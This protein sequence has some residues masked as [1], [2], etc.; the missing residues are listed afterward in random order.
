M[1]AFYPRRPSEQAVVKGVCPSPPRH[2]PPFLSRIRFSMITF[3]L[4][5]SSIF[6]EFIYNTSSNT[7]TITTTT[8]TTTTAA[9]ST[10]QA[11]E[12]AALDRSPKLPPRHSRCRR[13]NKGDPT[14]ICTTYYAACVAL[15]RVLR[16]TPHASHFARHAPHTLPRAPHITPR[17]PRITPHHKFRRLHHT[18]RRMLRRVSHV[19][20]RTHHMLRRAAVVR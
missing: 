2:L 14:A 10:P 3:Q 12:R 15:H 20:R 13:A 17:V 1:R 16:F 5:Y 6:I 9:V 11:E 18:L 8:T 19:L 7:I 4:L